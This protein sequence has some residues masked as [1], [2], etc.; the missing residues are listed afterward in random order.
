MLE[1]EEKRDVDNGGALNGRAPLII[2]TTR[3][4]KPDGCASEPIRV[5]DDYLTPIDGRGTLP[6]AL[7]ALRK[8]KG[9]FKLVVVGAVSEPHLEEVFE[10]RLRKW[11][12]EFADLKP[13]FVSHEVGRKLCRRLEDEGLAESNRSLGPSGCGSLRNLGLMAAQILGAEVAITMR[14]D[15]IVADPDF[16]TKATEFLGQTHAGDKVVAKV[17]YSTSVQNGHNHYRRPWWERFWG[18]DESVGELIEKVKAPPRLRKACLGTGVLVL[19]RSVFQ[20]VAFDPHIPGGECCD[21]ILSARSKDHECFSDNELLVDSIARPQR[22]HLAEMR[23]DFYRFLY[24]RRKLAM[25]RNEMEWGG[26]LPDGLEGFPNEFFKPTIPFKCASLALMTAGRD[27]L[28]QDFFDHLGLLKVV[29]WDGSR[30]AKHHIP[31]SFELQNRWPELMAWAKE[32][33]EMRD[34]LHRESVA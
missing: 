21:Y 20:Q 4:T 18:K 3:W 8:I 15:H 9:D 10:K 6:H 12:E 5:G 2:I 31:D 29:F 1:L 14:D 33:R 34:Y 11:L 19:T 32:D 28:K 24:G 23:Q 27:F 30:F 7:N 13:L 16:L 25:A 26:A 22:S 17:G